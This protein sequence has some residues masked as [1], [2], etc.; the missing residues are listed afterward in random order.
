[1]ADAYVPEADALEQHQDSAP[2]EDVTAE[3]TVLAV[4][5]VP[6]EASEADV[7]EQHD[8]VPLDEDDD[9]R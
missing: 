5:S 6:V 2:A 7:V 1:M 8:E 9:R 4:P 3:G